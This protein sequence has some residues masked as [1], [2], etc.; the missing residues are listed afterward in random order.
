MFEIE[1]KFKSA[2]PNQSNEKSHLLV[3]FSTK[4]GDLT[5]IISSKQ[6]MDYFVNDSQPEPG[7]GW[8]LR[9][10][11]TVIPELSQTM[12]NLKKASP[13]EEPSLNPTTSHN[14]PIILWLNKI[15]KRLGSLAVSSQQQPSLGSLDTFDTQEPED[16]F[17]AYGYNYQPN[18]NNVSSEEDDE[19]P[20]SD[21]KTPVSHDFNLHQQ[22][23][24][25][26]PEKEALNQGTGSSITNSFFDDEDDN[27]SNNDAVL[28]DQDTQSSSE[29]SNNDNDT[30]ATT[31][32][33]ADDQ[34]QDVDQQNG[35]LDAGPLS[36]DV[37][38]GL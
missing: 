25:V 1:A 37:S 24:I 13:I 38:S 17:S 34:E 23:K 11:T 12:L 35:P 21:V 10:E 27:E 32:L 30:T 15:Y 7:S 22:K 18:V 6:W 8:K 20:L 29:T 4:S 36:V 3:N 19:E 28:A 26:D 33:M 9:L 14:D 5:L 2:K 16:D 31:N